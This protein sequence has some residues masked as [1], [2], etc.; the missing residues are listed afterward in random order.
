MRQ[1]RKAISPTRRGSALKI[2]GKPRPSSRWPGTKRVSRRWPRSAGRRF[3]PVA[4]IGKERIAEGAP[5]MPHPEAAGRGQAH[6]HADAEPESQEQAPP[7]RARRP[8]RK[9]R[10]SPTAKV[11]RGL[12]ETDADA[13]HHGAATPR[14]GYSLRRGPPE[15]IASAPFMMIANAPMIG[16]ADDIIV[17]G[18]ADEGDMAAADDA[19]Q[20]QRRRSARSAAARPPGRSSARRRRTPARTAERSPGCGQTPRR[21]ETVLRR[22][23]LGGEVSRDIKQP[24][25]RGSAGAEVGSCCGR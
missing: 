5:Q 1:S 22:K 4:E 8:T 12:L 13:E 9:A 7:E 24:D 15:K 14:P 3:Q 21:K 11:T 25:C 10:Q 17:E 16:E 23:N 6:G 20:R 18:G 2:R 19:H